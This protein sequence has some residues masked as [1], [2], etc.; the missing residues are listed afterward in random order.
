MTTMRL[1]PDFAL[2][3]VEVRIGAATGLR[4]AIIPWGTDMPT[5]S[6]EKNGI[7]F[8]ASVRGVVVSRD[9]LRDFGAAEMGGASLMG[10]FHA[11]KRRIESAA[12][13]KINDGAFEPDGSVLLQSADF[14]I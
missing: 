5:V 4:K 2:T 9:A 1:C 8:T 3:E 12:R 6:V 11:K 13:D 14:W 10:A 7:A